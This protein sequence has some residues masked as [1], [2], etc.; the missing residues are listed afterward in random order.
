MNRNYTYCLLTAGLF[1]LCSF[2]MQNTYNMHGNK[3]LPV[4]IEFEDTTTAYKT[5]LRLA[6]RAAFKAR[7]IEVIKQDELTELISAEIRSTLNPY[8]TD[9]G[10]TDFDKMQQYLSLNQKNIANYLK[11]GIYIDSAGNVR[12]MV[13]WKNSPEPVN[14]KQPFKAQWKT[15]KLDSTQNNNIWQMAQVV[16]DSIIASNVLFKDY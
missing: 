13:K 14:M 15:I 5:E 11:L 7:N 6:F 1:W 12:D 16:T 9:G 2:T 10:T 8:F 4:F 3:Y